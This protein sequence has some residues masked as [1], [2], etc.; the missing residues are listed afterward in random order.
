[1]NT[2]A[3]P[4]TYKALVID[5]W[6]ILYSE[7]KAIVYKGYKTKLWAATYMARSW[8]SG[9]KSV[10]YSSDIQIPMDIDAIAAMLSRKA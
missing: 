1:M 7:S 6:V 9:A 2:S 8:I 3:S 5:D 4:T 10:H